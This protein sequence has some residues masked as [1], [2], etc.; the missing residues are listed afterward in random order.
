[1]KAI[2]GKL[3]PF[4]E[5]GT[6]G[7]IWSVY[8]D[9]KQGYAGLHCLQYGDYLTIF[10]PDV[11]ANIL[12]EGN[13]HYDSAGIQVGVE[14]EDWTNWFNRKC[15]AE[16]ITADF[17]HL[18]AVIGSSTVAGYRYDATAGDLTIKFR[19]GGF[20]RYKDVPFEAFRAFCDAES[21][22]KHLA[23]SIKDMYISEKLELPRPAKFST[24]KPKP[25]GNYPKDHGSDVPNAW[26]FP[27]SKKP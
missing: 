9:G 5:T 21:K 24:N 16:L 2:K 14:S 25:H 20:Y 13:I 8:E 3:D 17:G 18:S 7:V 12:W 22:G 1:M 6:E 4:F 10:D 15:S 11:T 19:N 27:T 23:Q 26:P